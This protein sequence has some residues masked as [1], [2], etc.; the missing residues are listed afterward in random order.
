MT[1]ISYKE[2]VVP[3]LSGL[4]HDIISIT[5][6]RASIRVSPFNLVPGQSFSV[7]WGFSWVS[8]KSF[9]RPPSIHVKVLWQS[10]VLYEPTGF[11]MVPF[12]TR[13]G[14][15]ESPHPLRIE[16]LEGNYPGI[17]DAFY[18]PGDKEI[19]VEITWTGQDW[20]G[21]TSGT[22]RASDWLTVNLEDP[23]DAW[24]TWR[25]ENWW[26]WRKPEMS[27]YMDESY[28]MNGKVTNLH[29]FADAKSVTVS[30][31][32]WE[33]DHDDEKKD[34][35]NR[36]PAP[37]S[38]AVHD[39]VLVDFGQ[40]KD[41]W[42]WFDCD[43]VSQGKDPI[44][45]I[46]KTFHYQVQLDVEDQFGNRYPAGVSDTRTVY[47]SVRGWDRFTSGFLCGVSL[48]GLVNKVI[49]LFSPASAG[50]FGG[51]Y[52]L[53]DWLRKGSLKVPEADADFK[54]KVTRPEIPFDPEDAA[55]GEGLPATRKFLKAGLEISVLDSM[56]R[57]IVGKML[58][59]RRA[60]QP[61]DEK[62]QRDSYSKVLGELKQK[63][64]TLQKLGDEAD[65]ELVELLSQGD[66][67]LPDEIRLE[68]LEGIEK[69]PPEAL[70]QFMDVLAS[71]DLEERVRQSQSLRSTAE[72]LSPVIAA[73]EEEDAKTLP[74]GS[75]G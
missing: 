12:G 16:D 70:D 31:W 68:E 44:I 35:P 34:F 2:K 73:I 22:V 69:L 33:D 72:A 46:S 47:V 56:R 66:V 28:S 39:T 25:S 64:Q 75:T 11:L 27:V 13:Y 19:A 17:S 43:R 51:F 62:S 9:T 30:L 54:S 24:W 58:G 63:V 59:A 74:G 40:F 4:L 20:D 61:R 55:F 10:Y 5:T 15:G 52:Y 3:N 6:K 57:S 65:A 21:V 23:V 71:P 32:K 36:A 8:S 53:E 37:F 14:T 67:Q 26:E 29:N 60:G 45:D 42:E 7:S 49:G 50:V 18:E 38:L 1:T 41:H 48:G